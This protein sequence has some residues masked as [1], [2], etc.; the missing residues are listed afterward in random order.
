MAK[1]AKEHAVGFSTLRDLDRVTSALE[2]LGREGVS[3]D[4]R[5]KIVTV[6]GAGY[7][8]VELAAAVAESLKGVAMVQLLSPSETI[9]QVCS[10]VALYLRSSLTCIAL[11]LPVKTMLG[12]SMQRFGHI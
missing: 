9:M 11:L 2:V 1:G 12:S 10:A 6:V 8:G 7:A 5:Q 4:S 3:Q